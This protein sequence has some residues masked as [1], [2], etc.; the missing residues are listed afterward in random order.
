MTT[1][2][3]AI[4]GGGVIGGGWAARF[5]LMGWDVQVFDPDAEAQRKV[6]E[7]LDNAR[8]SLPGLSDVALPDEGVLSFH[9]TVAEAVTG[10][11]WVQESVPE[12]LDLKH[13]VYADIQAHC[14]VD[15]VIGSSTSGFKPSQLQENAAR[16]DQ[17]VV[18]HP[19]NPVYLLPLI[20][21]VPSAV[22]KPTIIEAAKTILTEIGMYPLHVRA[23]IDAH[24]ADR[25]LEAVWR[26]ALWLIK[27]GIA[28]TEEI[29]NAIRYG[30]G[31]RWAQ[32]G[33]FETY[34]IAGGEAGMRHF[35]AQFGPCLSW[36]WTKLMDVPE[37]TETL[38]NQIADQSDAQSGHHSIRELERI[39][40]NNLVT[41]LRGLKA[42]DYG[43]GELLN[44]QDKRVKSLPQSLDNIDNLAKPIITIS[45][46][47]PLDWTDYN[48]HMNE[49]RY[50]QAFGDATDQMMALV[51]CDGD[52]IASGGSYFTAE[53]HIRHLDEVH[54]GAKIKIATQVIHGEG[55]KMHLFHRMY[56]GDRLLATGEHMLIHVSLETRKASEPDARVAVPL[57]KVAAAHAGLPLPEGVGAAIGAKRG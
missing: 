40:D 39:R 11:V 52:Y 56:E 53:T 12:R 21:L 6:G 18:T 44:A 37:L 19:F 50:L 9:D 22:T 55:K 35:I 29:D 33:L 34:R 36:P 4:I 16:P 14:A 17:I 15:A 20:E 46:A 45:R 24:I 13:R 51:G 42:Q 3:A 23:E 25:F 30:F 7:V 31:L 1:K 47:V 27:D 38:T 5:L 41:I 32:M 10:A 57:A 28:T 26:E 8:R 48:G 43:A 49:A 2:I 54:A